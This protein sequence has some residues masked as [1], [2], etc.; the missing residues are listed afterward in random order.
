MPGSLV[1]KISSLV[2]GASAVVNPENITTMMDNPKILRHIYRFYSPS[3]LTTSTVETGR[4]AHLSN[5]IQNRDATFLAFVARSGAFSRPAQ[6]L[7]FLPD[8]NE[9]RKDQT[10]RCRR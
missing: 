6:S 8:S 5:I 3:R 4:M 2:T 7:E 9:N 1:V 10:A